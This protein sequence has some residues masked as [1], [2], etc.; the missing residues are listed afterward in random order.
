MG[1]PLPGLSSL[2]ALPGLSSGGTG[3]PGPQL[4]H[5][6]WPPTWVPLAST[7][8]EHQALCSVRCAWFHVHSLYSTPLN[9]KG[10]MHGFPFDAPATVTQILS[11]RG[12]EVKM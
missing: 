11:A 10:K 1:R 12:K 8:V 4:P 6:P 7:R 9:L 5:L 3:Q 2:P